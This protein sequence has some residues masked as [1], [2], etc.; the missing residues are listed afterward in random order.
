MAFFSRALNEPTASS[1]FTPLFRLLDDYDTYTNPANPAH[2]KNKNHH[3]GSSIMQTFN[4]KF[5]VQERSDA[6][7]LH[8]EFP[9]L[10]RE[11][12]DI[13]FT[14]AQTLSVKGHVERIHEEGTKP[15]AIEGSKDKKAIEEGKG[16]KATVE[17]EDAQN[18]GS[19]EVATK[20]ETKAEEKHAAAEAKFWISERSVGEFSRSFTFPVRVDQDG[21]TASMKNGVLTIMVPKAKKLEGRKITIG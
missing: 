9:G 20:A 1:S 13:E 11:N 14:D 5:D 6:Y 15:A 12:I 21:V 7:H 18:G 16:K 10:E 4:P 8:G 19:T 2:H 3:R 17:D